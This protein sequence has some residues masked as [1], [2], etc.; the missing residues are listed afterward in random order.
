M[1]TQWLI[2]GGTHRAVLF[3]LWNP[4]E[5]FQSDQRQG[6]NYGVSQSL[7]GGDNSGLRFR[8]EQVRKYLP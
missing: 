4:E 7:S 5:C 2:P 6:M 8:E 3:L 1:V